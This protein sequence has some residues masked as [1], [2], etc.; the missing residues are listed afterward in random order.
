MKK[1]LLFLVLFLVSFVGFG[2]CPTNGPL[3]LQSQ[4]EI[5]EFATTYS[6]CT[7]FDTILINGSLNDIF[8]LE[9]LS[10]IEI[11]NGNFNINETNIENFNGLENLES[12]GYRFTI[13]ENDFLQNAQGLS[14]LETVGS[15]LFFHGNSSLQNLSGFDSLTSIGDS[16]PGGWGLQISYNF[17]LISLSGLENLSHISGSMELTNNYAL[18]DLSGL[19]GLVNIY[20][21]FRISYSRNLQNLNGLEALESIEGTLIIKGNDNL[22]SIDKLENLDPQSIAEDGYL[23]EDNPNLSVCDIDFIC[24]N[25]NYPGVQINDNAQG[26]NSVPE[27]EAQCQLSITGEDLSQSLSIFPNLVSST[28]QIN[29][30]NSIIFEKAIVYSTLGRLILETSEK[31]INLE[32]LS[33]GIY[34]VEVVTDKGSVIKKIVKE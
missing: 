19:S 3:V 30:S 1:G 27:V 5:D 13:A 8:N 6:G 17:S 7:E 32:T 28:L 26:C 15:G 14:S 31:Q 22:Q 23:I 18:E 2:Q 25:L 24:Q 33:A 34:F 9:G 11:I 20:G 21:G 12:I 4:A 29:T 10:Q 16:I